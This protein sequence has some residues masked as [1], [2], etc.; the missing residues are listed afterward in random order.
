MVDPDRVLSAA[1]AISNGI[2]NPTI[3]SKAF[4]ENVTWRTL[5][6]LYKIARLSGTHKAWKKD[7]SDAFNDSRFFGSSV[8]L[9]KT[10]WLPLLKQWTLSD[11]ERMSEL[12]VRLTPPT[13][14]GIVFGVGATSA[15]LEAD[16]KSQ[17]NLRRIATLI[18]AAATDHFVTE[19]GTLEV[20]LVELLAATSTSSPSSTTRADIFMV[21]HALLLKISPIHLAPFWPI[22]NAEL[23]ASISSV[24]VA[25]ASMVAET[26]NHQ[27]TLQACRLLDVLLC[28]SPDDFQLHEWL[29]ITDTIDAC[30]RPP[31]SR[32]V[33]LIDELAE[34]LDSSIH[35]SPSHVEHTTSDNHIDKSR[36][37]PLLGVGGIAYNKESLVDKNELVQEV[38]RPFFSQLSIFAF[39]RTYEM[40]TVDW[41][42]CIRA[43]LTDLFDEAGIV[44]TL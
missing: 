10:N 26:Y 15:R 18:L 11:K 7:L 13:T 20:K 27:S 36:R 17:L 12:I 39:E 1:T 34:E 5:D 43:L 37:R 23:H 31:N 42:L 2:I 8:G 38:L 32:A 33:G 4:P 35:T 24:I 30:H 29:Y 16:R 9:V 40:G 28:I 19:L 3:R 14:A 25:D 21:L 44:K 41:D 6:L 22:I